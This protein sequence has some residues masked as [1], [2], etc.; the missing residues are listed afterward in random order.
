MIQVNQYINLICLPYAGGALSFFK[1]WEEFLDASIKILPIEL[2]GRGT[3]YD[4]P[5]PNSIDEVVNDIFPLIKEEIETGI[6]YAIF[7]HSLGT[8]VAFELAK[9]IQ[10][11]ELTNPL[12]VF[13]SGRATPDTKDNSLELAE[14]PDDYFIE[15]LK[16]YPGIPV[17]IIKYPELLKYFLPVM[18][19][20]LQLVGNYTPRRSIQNEI[21]CDISV[22]FGENDHNY[23]LEDV[24]RWSIVTNADSDFYYFKGGH[25]F[26][27]EFAKEVVEVINKT[28][29][30][31]SVDER[32]Y[33]HET[34]Q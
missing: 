29:K 8:L 10:D 24:K 21:S 15:E 22:L 7:G 18:R 6:P 17:E 27:G 16:N 34:V 31:Y 14:K 28:L 12:H 25:F 30:K 9:R 4:E 1:S 20:D 2:Q 13:F 11:E 19:A 5:F 26:V 33:K 23:K 3:R 32:E